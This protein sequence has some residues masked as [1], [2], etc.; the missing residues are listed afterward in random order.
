MDPLFN[1][2]SVAV[3]GVSTSKDN[4]GKNIV[5]NLVNFGYGGKIYPVGPRRDQVE[6]LPI[7]PSVADL[8]ETPD[9]AVILT[10]ARFVPDIVSQCG[11]RGIRWAVIQTGGFRESGADGMELE[12]RLVEAAERHGLR[13]VGPNCLGVMDTSTGFFVPFIT[14]PSTYR[15]G[16]VAVMAQSGGMGLSL[17]ERLSTSGVGFGKFVS[18][19]NKLNLDE[20]GYLKYLMEDPKTDIIY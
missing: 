1:P 11:E 13:F 6:G 20:A 19:G 5:K 4:L 15:K 18:L 7:Y 10:P 2:Q 12:K 14:L 3:V 8:P 16:T 9:V 17:V